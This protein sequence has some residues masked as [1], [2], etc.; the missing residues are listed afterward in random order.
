MPDRPRPAGRR[1]LAPRAG[2]A[3]GPRASPRSPHDD[4]ARTAP[5]RP[6]RRRCPAR[7]AARS[8][9]A[10][11]CCAASLAFAERRASSPVSR[12]RSCS[13][14]RA[15]S[16][17]LPRVLAAAVQL[18]RR[19]ASRGPAATPRAAP[20]AWSARC[21]S[22]SSSL[23][24]RPQ[25]RVRRR[26]R[27]LGRGQVPAELLVPALRLP[28]PGG[29]ALGG[30]HRVPAVMAEEVGRGLAR[31]CQ[32]SQRVAFLIQAAE[33]LGDRR[34]Q[35]RAERGQRLGQRAGQQLLVG[36]LGKLRL[37]ELDQQVDQRLVAVLTEPE[38][39][40]VHRP[41]VVG[42]P[43]VHQPVPVDLLAQLFPGERN[44]ARRAAGAGPR[45]PAGS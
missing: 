21:S 7:R 38:Q 28:W 45:R 27:L 24:R 42:G 2:P 5:P 33:R 8:R 30:D 37:P 39:G 41:P 36:L 32:G 44:P 12:S 22:S 31:L 16:S 40:L 13:R 20:P 35:A 25:L 17:L 26:V 9:A 14:S 18:A 29:L 15:V 23:L 11:A 10:D 4:P 43:V 19:R 3:A 6:R 1:P 34:H